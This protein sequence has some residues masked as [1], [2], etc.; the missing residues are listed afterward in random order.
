MIVPVFK[1]QHR[2]LTIRSRL[3]HF[4]SHEGRPAN[5]RR[6]ELGYPPMWYLMVDGRRCPVL[7]YDSAQPLPE[8]DAALRS[9]AGVN[10]LVPVDRV[11]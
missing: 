7:P 6:A 11:V 4:V 1:S 10:A 9:W 2:R 8:L 5:F 3:F